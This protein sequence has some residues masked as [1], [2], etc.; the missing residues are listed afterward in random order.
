M[1]EQVMKKVLVILAHPNFAESRGNKA[2]VEAVQEIPSVKIHYLYERYPNWQID[3]QVEQELLRSHDLIVLQH[4]LQWYS[5]PPLLKKWMDDV[6]TYGFAYGE[7][8]TALKGKELMPV[9]TAGGL[10]EMYVAGG[11]VNFTMSEL[12]RPIQQTANFCG[13]SYKTPFVVHGF[14]PKELEIPG[15]IS[16][17]QLLQASNWYKQLLQQCVAS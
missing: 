16:D 7:A 11:A 14:L 12:L 4:P 17:E 2:L 9:V 10:S 1:A 15:T 6:L 13:M 5:V 3:V 8:G